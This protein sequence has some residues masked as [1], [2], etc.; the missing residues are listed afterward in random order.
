MLIVGGKMRVN[1]E[2]QL[3]IASKCKIAIA[4]CFEF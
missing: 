4:K 3:K 2:K 1:D